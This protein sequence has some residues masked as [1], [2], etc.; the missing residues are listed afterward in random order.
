MWFTQKIKSLGADFNEQV[1]RED[2]IFLRNHR[3]G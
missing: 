2:G 1:R 3:Y